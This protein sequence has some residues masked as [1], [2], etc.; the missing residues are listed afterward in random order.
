MQCTQIATRLHA[1]SLAS[2]GEGEYVP[3]VWR[4]GA[5]ELCCA[6]LV[7]FGDD[8]SPERSRTWNALGYTNDPAA[9]KAIPKKHRSA[10]AHARAPMAANHEELGDIEGV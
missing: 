7:E 2:A 10:A 4:A 3:S 8:A 5:L 9:W 6:P 1:S